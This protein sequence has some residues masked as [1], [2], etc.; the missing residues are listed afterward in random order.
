M[1]CGM[2]TKLKTITAWLL[3]QCILLTLSTACVY[4]GCV[5]VT[6]LKQ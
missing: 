2:K 5:V 6:V 1:V 4:I 3:A